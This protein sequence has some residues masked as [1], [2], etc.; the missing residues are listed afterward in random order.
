M[1]TT[2][3]CFTREI[4]VPAL[5][6]FPPPRDEVTLIFENP[7]DEADWGKYCFIVSKYSLRRA[8]RRWAAEFKEGATWTENTQNEVQI[9]PCNPNALYLILALAHGNR[10][11]KAPE[12]LEVDEIH[13][14]VVLCDYLDVIDLTREYITANVQAFVKTEKYLAPGG[15]GLIW[16]CQK[17]G[18][19]S[20]YKAI[21][22][23]I[24]LHIYTDEEG[25]CLQR[26]GYKLQEDIMPEG[27]IGMFS[28]PQ[29]LAH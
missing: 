27:F 24:L 28:H 7:K 1:R 11:Q 6:G 15:E 9:E 12:N 21:A 8:S 2:T 5:L 16:V 26:R 20:E 4:T 3:Y 14:L 29:T 13:P 17:L 18:L 22:Q 23:G 25:S 19:L 10:F